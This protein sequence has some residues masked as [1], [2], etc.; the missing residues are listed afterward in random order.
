MV[1][2]RTRLACSG[3]VSATPFG[4]VAQARQRMPPKDL[5]PSMFGA[6]PNTARVTR[7]LPVANLALATDRLAALFYFGGQMGTK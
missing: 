5:P 6:T 7:A 4:E 3:A 1:G 2:E